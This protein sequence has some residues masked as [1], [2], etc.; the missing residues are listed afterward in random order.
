[1]VRFASAFPSMTATLPNSKRR[2]NLNAE[3]SGLVEVGHVTDISIS[4]KTVPSNG[5]DLSDKRL[6]QATD[7]AQKRG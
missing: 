5:E 4:E 6:H 2:Q 3:E 1:L 7:A